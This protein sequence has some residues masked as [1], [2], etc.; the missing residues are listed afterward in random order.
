MRNAS[1]SVCTEAK[2]VKRARKHRFV[3]RGCRLTVIFRYD[4]RRIRYTIDLSDWSAPEDLLIDGGEWSA[5]DTEYAA[6]ARAAAKDLLYSRS[7]RFSVA[8]PLLA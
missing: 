6:D 1:H 4:R 8:P 2:M 5:R 3:L 7:R